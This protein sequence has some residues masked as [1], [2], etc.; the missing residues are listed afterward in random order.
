VVT[1]VADDPGMTTHT[2]TA[3]LDEAKLGAFME[4]ALGDASGLM[5]TVPAGLGD[6]LGLFRALTFNALHAVRP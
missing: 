4:H 6:R 1:H 3:P 2:A 5:A